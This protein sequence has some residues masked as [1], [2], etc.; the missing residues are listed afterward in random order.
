[1]TWCLV[2]W[3]LMQWSIFMLCSALVN[4]STW[5]KGRCL[6]CTFCFISMQWPVYP[7]IHHNT[8]TL[9]CRSHLLVVLVHVNS[10]QLRCVW[11]L[12]QIAQEVCQSSSTW[13]PH[14]PSQS[15]CLLGAGCY[16]NMIFCIY[17]RLMILLYYSS[18]SR[19]YIF[20]K[21]PA[22]TLKTQRTRRV[23]WSFQLRTHK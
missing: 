15:T 1:M 14:G 19:V 7:Y 3:I 11:S 16:C 18:L 4:L 12:C 6:S 9:C 5:W 23:T 13:C 21:N 2:S 22:A 17:R 10:F 8:H 20:S